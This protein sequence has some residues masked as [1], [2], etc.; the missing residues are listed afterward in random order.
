M[1]I[2]RLRGTLAI[3]K[4]L[5]ISTIIIAMVL[6]SIIAPVYAENS[7]ATNDA[8]ILD[9]ISDK[10]PGDVVTISGTTIFSEISIKVLD[11]NK[12]ILYVSAVKGKS[13]TDTFTLP[14]GAKPGT[15]EVVAGVGATV[16]TATFKVEEAEVPPVIV[17]ID[18]VNVTTKAGTAP[19]LPSEVIARYS[20]GSSKSVAVV[21]DEIEPSQYAEAGTFTV[22]GTV[23]GTSIKAKA[24]VIVTPLIVNEVKLD[25][26]PDKKPGDTVTITGTT[27]FGEI[28][29]KVLAPNKTVLYVSTAKGANF[30]KTFTLPKDAKPGIYEVVAGVGSIVA[31]TTFKVEEDEVPPTIVSIDEVNVTT[32]AGTAPVLPAEVTARYSDGSSKSV[33]VVWDEI[34]PSQYA[35]AGTFTVEG[36]VEGTSIKAKATVTVEEVEVPPVIVSIDEVSVTTKA[37]TAPVLPS[38]VTARYSDGSSKSV[39]VVWDEI[40]PSQY[41]EAGTFT[42][43]GTVEGTSIKAKATVIVTPLIVNEVKLDSIPDKKP[44]DTVTITGTTTFGEITIKVIAPNKT[45]LYIGT[46]KGGNFT[47]TFTLPKDAKPGVYEIVAGVG[48]TVATATF[49]VEAIVPPTIV[50]IDEVNVTTKAGTAPVL[51]AEVTARYSD[52]SSKNVAVVWDEIDPAQYAKAGTFTVEGT[53]EGTDIK[54]IARVRVTAADSG[55]VMPILT[56]DD[57]KDDST[58]IKAEHYAGLKYTARFG[59]GALRKAIESE[60]DGIARLKIT[61]TEEAGEIL[62]N[63][64]A[65]GLDLAMENGIKAIEI[66]S[67]DVVF[68]INPEI[69]KNNKGEYPSNIELSVRKVDISSLP[70][71]VRNAVGDN[72]VYDFTLSVDG[73]KI[74]SFNKGDVAISMKYTLKPGED[75]NKVVVYYIDDNGSIQVVTNG[76]YNPETGMVEF[77]PE[78]LSMY[79]AS[80]NDVTFSDISNVKWAKEAIEYLAARGIISGPGDGTF[81]PSDKVTRAEF[82]KMLMMALELEDEEAEC[83]FSDV[84]AGA[85]YY[86]PIAAAQKL[87]IVK[88]KGDGTF[89]V[90]DEILRQDMAVMIYRT[91]QLLGIDLDDDKDVVPFTDEAEISGYAKEA[92]VAIQKAGIIKGTGDGSFA[93]KKNVTRAEAAVIIYRVNHIFPYWNHMNLF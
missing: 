13:F 2:L 22:E 25:S 63:I 47:K 73:K 3:V 18:E 64:P 35:E 42:V 41:T 85:W 52:G 92:V 23:E 5:Y 75:P 65:E 77:R 88:G 8:V 12:T 30:T 60:K 93:P 24:T 62:I 51:P 1:R 49:K 36:T 4:R 38:E 53:V 45:V 40:D 79:T 72:T 86:K 59:K 46:A 48:S 33:A 37:G 54:A 16:A 56:E 83:T 43:E 39:A 17:S 9:S 76:R 32:K 71:E 7:P 66:E 15:Y 90:N 6:A 58:E 91:A 14:K 74:G 67:G 70:E 29:I 57:S 19:V 27:T 55:Y 44:G 68:S 81:R 20:D 26:I 89:G 50:S 80:Y 82:I 84:K 87:G 61:G 11:P 69:L 78:H 10:A 21:W 34:E 31:T 28:S